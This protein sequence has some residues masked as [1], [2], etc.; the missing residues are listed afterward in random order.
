[1]SGTDLERMAL[2]GVIGSI[3]PLLSDPRSTQPIASFCVLGVDAAIEALLRLCSA[4]KVRFPPP[5][6][7]FPRLCSRLK[8]CVL[9]CTSGVVPGVVAS[10]EARTD[11]R[12]ISIV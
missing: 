10:S 7:S 11:L 1:M 5:L 2:L 8:Y 12:A 6:Y 3:G 4:I 9:V